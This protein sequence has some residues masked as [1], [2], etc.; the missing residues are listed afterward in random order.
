MPGQR[1]TRRSVTYI[2]LQPRGTTTTR[3][4]RLGLFLTS[5]D[6][7]LEP[8]RV[9][10]ERTDEAP[11]CQRGERAYAREEVGSRRLMRALVDSR[12]SSSAPSRVI[13]EA[14]YSPLSSSSPAPGV[15]RTPQRGRSCVSRTRSRAT[16]ASVPVTSCWSRVRYKCGNRPHG[17]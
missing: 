15:P 14:S 3:T 5:D 9:Y 16:P 17:T 12:N 1:R 8:A 11:I 4:I 10:Q 2:I 7:L 13:C 6:V